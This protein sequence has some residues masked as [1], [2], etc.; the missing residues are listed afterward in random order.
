LG[1]KAVIVFF[2]QELKILKRDVQVFT[3]TAFFF[4]GAFKGNLAF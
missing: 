2:F 4:V 3:P 1:T